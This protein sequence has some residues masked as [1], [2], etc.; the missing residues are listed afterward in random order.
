MI[1]ILIS[2]PRCCFPNRTKT[3]SCFPK[4]F[5]PY[6]PFNIYSIC[7][8]VGL[9]ELHFLPFLIILGYTQVAAK[10][11]YWKYESSRSDNIWHIRKHMAKQQVEW[12]MKSNVW[13]GLD[14]F[15]PQKNL[16]CQVAMPIQLA[17]FQVR[18]TSM[19]LYKQMMSLVNL[20]NLRKPP[21][22][23][24][25]INGLQRCL[26]SFRTSLGKNTATKQQL[27]AVWNN[28]RTHIEPLRSTVP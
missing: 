27:E 17:M 2:L 14:S 28:S 11:S 4:K 6:L 5:K 13:L 9:Y 18:V 20:A 15:P 10:N 8:R 26:Q 21:Q 7:K 19:I 1:G 22:S 23:F 25:H 12:S 3:P 24:S 16:T